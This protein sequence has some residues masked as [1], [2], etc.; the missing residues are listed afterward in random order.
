MLVGVGAAATVFAWLNALLKLA[1]SRGRTAVARRP[2]PAAYRHTRR[3]PPPQANEEWSLFCPNEAPGLADCW[4]PE[5][6]ALYSKYE[7]EGRPRKVIKAQT[8]W[9]AILEAQARA[10]AAVPGCRRFSRL[11]TPRRR[12]RLAPSP[13]SLLPIPSC[14][15]PAPAR[16][17]RATRTCC[18]RTRPTASPTSRTWAPSSH[19]TCAPVRA[20][21]TH[22]SAATA[23]PQRSAAVSFR[24]G[25]LP[26][27]AAAAGRT[28]S[29]G[30]PALPAQG[31]CSRRPEQ[32]QQHRLLPPPTPHPNPH[33]PTHPPHSPPA[34]RDP[35]V[36]QPRRDC[37]LQPGIHRAA[38]LCP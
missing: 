15:A 25:R 2:P 9:F 35:G 17:R 7:A 29:C 21:G 20:G 12:A 32:R 38:P 5:F 30:V 4:G 36:H 23:Q 11:R 26:T 13:A 27:G 34:R 22:H 6:E 10:S 33:P 28:S 24:R 19:P 1:V 14:P 8:L 31:A 16:W 18:T 3:P 37:R